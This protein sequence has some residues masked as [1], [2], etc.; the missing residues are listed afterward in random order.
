MFQAIR[1]DR[2]INHRR[3]AGA[4]MLSFL[5]LVSLAGVSLLSG[6][7]LVEELDAEHVSLVFTEFDDMAP[8]PPPK[9]VENGAA[10]ETEPE[11]QVEPEP[12]PQAEPDPEVD[13]DPEPDPAPVVA[14]LT[15]PAGDPDG[16][17]LGVE[18][19]DSIKGK[20][21]GQI[22]GTGAS[23]VPG[24]TGVK[25]VSASQVRARRQVAPVY[26]AAAKELGLEGS[27]SLRFQ[28]DAKGRVSSVNVVSCPT[29]FQS[30]ALT[31]AQKWTFY[32]YKDSS[33]AKHAASFV[34]RLEFRLD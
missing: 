22:G 28:V 18:G 32:P 19:G 17:E 23:T 5:G 25:T 10:Q 14:D 15:G 20:P 16:H 24:G 33:G 26:P 12:E 31:A 8:P 1:E 7:Q 2:T 6:G 29:A 4:A 11:T 13:P 27:C 21:G 9:G 3:Q 34:L 30:A